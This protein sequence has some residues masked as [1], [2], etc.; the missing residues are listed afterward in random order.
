VRHKATGPAAVGRPVFGQQQGP[1]DSLQS[2]RTGSTRRGN[3]GRSRL[4][5]ETLVR[6]PELTNRCRAAVWGHWL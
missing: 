4:P 2:L 6:R 5:S 1:A 3:V